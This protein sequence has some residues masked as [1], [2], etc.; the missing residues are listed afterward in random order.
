MEQIWTT[1]LNSASCKFP[2]LKKWTMQVACVTVKIAPDSCVWVCVWRLT[3]DCIAIQNN[4]YIIKV[5]CFTIDDWTIVH[6]QL[7]YKGWNYITCTLQYSI[8]EVYILTYYGSGIFQWGRNLI[9]SPGRMQ[10]NC[11]F[12]LHRPW[13]WFRQAQST[14]H[15]PARYNLIWSVKK[16]K[17]KMCQTKM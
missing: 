7:E 2:V 16:R 8:T 13:H 11:T 9:L 1:Y 5:F 6:T 3:F 12:G 17:C 4:N 10:R 15:D 14:W